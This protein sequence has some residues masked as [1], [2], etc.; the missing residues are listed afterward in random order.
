[1]NAALSLSHNLFHRWESGQH[2]IPWTDFVKLIQMIGND[3]DAALK[4]I[5]RYEDG[6]ENFSALLKK[7]I[8]HSKPKELSRQLKISTLSLERWLK[9]KNEIS[10]VDLFR[11]MHLCTDR[12]LDFLD[13]LL[14]IEKLPAV[15]ASAELLKF[16]RDLYFEKPWMALVPRCLELKEYKTHAVHPVGFL[17]K[18]L[19]ISDAEE[20]EAIKALLRLGILIW[21]DKKLS[22]TAKYLNT[23]DV[24]KP[25]RVFELF[26]YWLGRHAQKFAREGSR[27][28]QGIPTQRS[29][30]SFR[31][32]TTNATTRALIEKKIQDFDR[33]ITNILASDLNRGEH[34]FVMSLINSLYDIP[35][36]QALFNLA[37][38]SI[39]DGAENKSAR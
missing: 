33:E 1:M 34:E 10:M 2:K 11:V 16:E 29:C 32:F 26:S 38:K 15:A 5:F 17:A 20:M 18:K 35:E 8:G 3:V 30:G 12:F 13:C 24:Q 14:E 9:G 22:I 36:E 31:V 21:E 6:A 4:K 27:L 23:D 19:G 25:W 39:S 28:R 37:P 7:L